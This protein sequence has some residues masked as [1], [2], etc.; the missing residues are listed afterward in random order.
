VRILLDTHV[1]IWSQESPERLGP[2]AREVLEDPT[3]KLVV[4][5]IS[6]L[7]LAQLA[8]RQRIVLQGTLGDWS[9]RALENLGAQVSPITPDIALAAYELPGPFHP[10]PA[11]RILVATAILDHLTLLTADERILACPRLRCL[12]AAV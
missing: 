6:F 9:R 2:E 5:A 12:A 10:D 7:E 4:S 1:W 8:H 3:H 11:D